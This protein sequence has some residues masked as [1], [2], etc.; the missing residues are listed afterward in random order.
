M[1][2]ITMKRFN[3][4]EYLKNPAR[5][6]V[7]GTGRNVRIVCTDRRNSGYPIV[8]L[9]EDEDKDKPDEVRTFTKDGCWNVAGDEISFNLF[10]APEKREGW[11]NLFRDSTDNEIYCSKVYPT[12]E[13]AMDSIG[14][15][16]A[17][18]KVEWE[19]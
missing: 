19:E 5:K 8:A 1:G 13:K 16:Y 4:D 3:L 11:I 6:V 2:R 18:I 15:F 17:T 7:T 14:A 9:I 10:F 12:K